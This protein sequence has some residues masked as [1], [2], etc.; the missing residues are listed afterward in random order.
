MSTIQYERVNEPMV[1]KLYRVADSYDRMKVAC[2]NPR[3]VA[4]QLRES[5]KRIESNK[6]AVHP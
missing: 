5:A 3:W 6:K 2:D 4:T 1:E